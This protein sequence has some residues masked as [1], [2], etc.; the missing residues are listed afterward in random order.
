M[1]TLKRIVIPLLKYPG[2]PAYSPKEVCYLQSKCLP[3]QKVA[4]LIREHYIKNPSEGTFLAFL[5]GLR[6]LPFKPPI[7]EGIWI[8]GDRLSYNW[9][10]ILDYDI[11]H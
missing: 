7:F 5:G 11:N 4:A 8:Y 1:K 6:E 10:S 9:V 2:L 3:F